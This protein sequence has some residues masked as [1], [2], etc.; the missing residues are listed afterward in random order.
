MCRP[1]SEIRTSKGV[2]ARFDRA[3]RRERDDERVDQAPG[4]DELAIVITET[5]EDRRLQEL[6]TPVEPDKGL[7]ALPEPLDGDLFFDV[8]GDIFAADGGLE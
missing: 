4:R 8:E 1:V 6:V 3:V 5:R 7:A 2:D